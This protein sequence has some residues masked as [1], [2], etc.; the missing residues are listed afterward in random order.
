MGPCLQREKLA[1]SG[2]DDYFEAVLVSED[3]GVA[4][5]ESAV[6]EHALS[7]IGARPDQTVMIGDSLAKDVDGALAAGLRAIWLNRGHAPQSRSRRELIE[8]STLND[9]PEAV[10]LLGGSTSPV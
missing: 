1:A 8:I 10:A 6:F 9:L 2:L 4:K 3:L 5:P 7:L